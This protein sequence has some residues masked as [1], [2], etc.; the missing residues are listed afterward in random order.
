[1]G[2]LED[3]RRQAPVV[4]VWIRRTLA[5]A[6]AHFACLSLP[7]VRESIALA[8]RGPEWPKGL[9]RLAWFAM[10]L[11]TFYQHCGWLQPEFSA[12]ARIG[13]QVFGRAGDIVRKF[14]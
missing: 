5:E 3:A 9:Y 14:T 11:C 10:R 4:G 13:S 12:S 7:R 2:E 8:T 6:D 1:V